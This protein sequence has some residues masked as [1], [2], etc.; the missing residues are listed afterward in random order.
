MKESAVC[1]FNVNIG[2]FRGVTEMSKRL[3]SILDENYYDKKCWKHLRTVSN[4]WQSSPV[5]AVDN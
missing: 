5:M 1:A 3:I 2:L 4:S